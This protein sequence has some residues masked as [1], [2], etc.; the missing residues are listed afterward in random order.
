MSNELHVLYFS[1]DLFVDVAATS[2][3]HY[4]KITN[5]LRL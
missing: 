3:V 4:S 2:I 1:S 5:L